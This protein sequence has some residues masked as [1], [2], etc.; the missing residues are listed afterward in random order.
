MRLFVCTTL[1]KEAVEN[2]SCEILNYMQEVYT[3]NTFFTVKTNQ[4]KTTTTTKQ[5]TTKQKQRNKKTPPPTTKTK[6]KKTSV[7]C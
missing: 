7:S 1:I 6:R 2:I 4:T 5:K 3:Y